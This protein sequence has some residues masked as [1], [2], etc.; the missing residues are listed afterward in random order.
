VPASRFKYYIHDSIATCRLQLIG[1]LSAEELPE[2]EGCWRTAQTTLDGR[3]L[4][5][6]TTQL[7]TA[8]EAGTLWLHTMAVGGATILKAE[9]EDPKTPKLGLLRRL[10]CALTAAESPTQA[11]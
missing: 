6:D 5:V 8:D 4:V 3:Q 11:Q 2:L 7:E 1:A 10:L 9:T